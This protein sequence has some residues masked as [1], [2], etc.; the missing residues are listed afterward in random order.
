MAPRWARAEP[1]QPTTLGG[2][3]GRAAARPLAAD[4]APD[5]DA[6]SR[7]SRAAGS[8]L[9]SRSPRRPPSPA[10]RAGRLAG[11]RPF[12]AREARCATW[13]CPA[14]RERAVGF[15]PRPAELPLADADGAPVARGKVPTDRAAPGA[16]SARHGPAG[17]RRAV[18]RAGAGHDGLR[19]AASRLRAR[20]HV[21]R[22]A[23]VRG[24]GTR[25]ARARRPA[26]G[27][28]TGQGRLRPRPPRRPA[29]GRRELA[30]RFAAAAK[31][32]TH[33]DW[34][35]RRPGPRPFP[36]APA[37]AGRGSAPR[38]R[39]RAGRHAAIALQ[40]TPCSNAAA[41]R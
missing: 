35:F 8:E 41:P 15:R 29:R 37:G 6:P 21:Q 18:G 39:Q 11:S 33:L 36:G 30:L 20:D 28:R 5:V 17:S 34:P 16:V 13:S 25:P 10:P 3:S 23:A 26:S 7:C 32:R 40:S 2:P 19:A 9:P 12:A 31:V 24:R 22:E 1:C 38:R 27:R 14:A 4:R